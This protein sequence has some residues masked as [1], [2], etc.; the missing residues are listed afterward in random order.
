[1]TDQRDELRA[2]RDALRSDTAVL[3][4]L[5]DAKVAEIPGTD[6]Q[7]ELARQA[8]AVGERIRLETRAEQDIAEELRNQRRSRN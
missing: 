3:D 5:E 6:R 1:M 2:T 7:V 8:T 4:K